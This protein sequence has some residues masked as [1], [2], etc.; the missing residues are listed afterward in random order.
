MGKVEKLRTASG[1]DQG[2]DVDVAGGDDAVEGRRHGLEALELLQSLDIGLRRRHIRLA[3]F[4]IGVLLVDVLLGHGVL[5]PQ[6]LPTLRGHPREL[7]V[8]LGL[9]QT[10]PGLI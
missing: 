3:G 1:V 8:G 5:Q 10:C 7:Q 2:P 9:L 4:I 6:R